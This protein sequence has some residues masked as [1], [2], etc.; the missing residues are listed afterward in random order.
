MENRIKS[1]TFGKSPERLVNP[2]SINEIV[3]VNKL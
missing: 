3:R 2:A 1:G